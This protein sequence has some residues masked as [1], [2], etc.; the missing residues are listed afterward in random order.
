M[1]LQFIIEDRDL[2]DNFNQAVLRRG[3]N[4]NDLI[5]AFLEEYVSDN[6]VCEGCKG[7]G[8]VE[9]PNYSNLDVDADQYKRSRCDE[10]N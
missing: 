7:E 5:E 1:R 3:D 10:C 4:V 6:P 8:F 2:V 9:L